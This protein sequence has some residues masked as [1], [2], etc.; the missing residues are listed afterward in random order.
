MAAFS[1]TRRFRILE[2]LGK[3]GMGIVY[4]ARDEETQRDI[5]LKTL[6]RVNPEDLRRLK[7]EFRLLAGILHPNLVELHE[8]F[9][10][11]GVAFFTMEVIEGASFLEHVWGDGLSDGQDTSPAATVRRVEADDEGLVAFAVHVLLA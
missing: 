11:D 9:V 7:D 8:L 5:A 4:R 6:R 10:E 2:T 3:G 1:G